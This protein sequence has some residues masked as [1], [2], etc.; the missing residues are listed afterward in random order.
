VLQCSLYSQCG[1]QYVSP[2]CY[3]PASPHDVT[4][5]ETNID[6]FIALRPPNFT[7]NFIHLLEAIEMHMNMVNFDIYL[8]LNYHYRM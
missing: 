4:T 5:Q 7:Q 3:L 6:I 1:R 8:L 2:K